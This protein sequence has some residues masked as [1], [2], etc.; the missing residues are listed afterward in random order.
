[1]HRIPLLVARSVLAVLLVAS[2]AEAQC[3]S[4]GSLDREYGQSTVVFVGTA[5][6][7][8]Y[9]PNTECCH[10]YSGTVTF[11]VTRWWK[12]PGGKRIDVGTY[13]YLFDA[14]REYVVFAGGNPP[15]TSI[16]D[17]SKLRSEAAETLR[18]LNEL[19]SS[20]G[21]ESW[22]SANRAVTRLP[23]DTFMELP[24]AVRHQ[25]TLLECAIP[26]PVGA[27]TRNVTHG[28][29][30]GTGSTDWAV[31]CSRHLT[32]SILV[33]D[34]RHPDRVEEL[35]SRPDDDFL[36][37]RRG[38]QIVFSR[39]IR[40]ASPEQV[41]DRQQSVGGNAGPRL[42][43]AGIEDLFVG[44]ASVVWYWHDGNWTLVGGS[45]RP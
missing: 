43:H 45:D 37:E 8:H 4:A 1:M 25:L 5:T 33:F 14:G 23:P 28:H 34:G 15:V 6:A 41:H 13:G 39:A 3:I 19:T 17:R 26:Q 29:F 12:G 18:W 11:D 27:A 21:A 16:C 9:L 10:V 42:A 22:A 20:T 32:S 44:K 36:Q 7:L 24:A 40:A 38:G 30:F 35:A 2:S 31:L